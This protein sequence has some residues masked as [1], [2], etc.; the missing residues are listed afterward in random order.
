MRID[1][2]QYF[3]LLELHDFRSGVY[4]ENEDTIVLDRTS[5]KYGEG[6]VDFN[7]KMDISDPQRTPFEFYMKANKINLKKLLPPFDYFNIKLLADIENQPENIS[8]EIKHRGI[9][10]DQKGL[11]PNT[12]NGEIK[13]EVDNGETL[14]GKIFYEPSTFSTVSQ[15]NKIGAV[16]T[17]IELEGNPIVFNEFFKTDEFFFD[18][19]DFYV[20]FEYEGNVT[21]FEELL[22]RSD[23]VFFMQN[24]EVFYKT[25]NVTFPVSELVL[26]LREDNA[27][28]QVYMWFDSLK[29]EI[30]LDGQIQNLSEL[31]LENT[32]KQIKSAVDLNAPK[33]KMKQ[34]AYI[35]APANVPKPEQ[36]QSIE[37]LKVTSIGLLNTFDPILHIYLDTFVYSEKLMI[38]ELETGVRLVGKDSVLL[39]KM[40]FKF[41]DGRV[42]VNGVCDFGTKDAAPF[43]AKFATNELDIVQ[44]FESLN[45]LGFESLKDIDYLS[46]STT[47][48][49]DLSGIID[50]DAKGLVDS[51]TNGTL[52]F[53]L[54]NIVIEGFEPLDLLAKKIKMK[55]RFEK[56]RFA[57]ITNLLT[58]KGN[59]IQ[60]PEMEIQSNAINMFIEGT[61][62]Y[63]ADGNG[64]HNSNNTN[65]WVSIPLDNLKSSDRSIIPKKRGYAATRRKVYLEL[66]ANKKGKNKFK[67]RTSK[68]KFYKHRGILN[69]YRED[70]KKYRKM[71]KEGN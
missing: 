34:L 64:K 68:R 48:N 54:R 18:K 5:F 62:S 49:L 15:H 12:S 52:E 56:I 1:T 53:E 19:G 50:D 21:N 7:V 59:D 27:D 35:F 13:F 28:F 22:N 9:L 26:N 31:L 44:V 45:H 30:N 29:Q 36:K 67:L 55:K 33:I 32:G 24:S 46:G 47:L 66:K 43:S 3:D 11:I 8:F 42:S 70:K 71:R 69:Q 57:P 61:L 37:A 65:L 38:E 63:A 60:I 40:S 6:E 51:A 16:K 25:A 10:D 23:A 4:F 39:E 41:H 17:K 20:H 14:W 2:L 58:I